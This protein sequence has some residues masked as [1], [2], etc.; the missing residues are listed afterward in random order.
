MRLH[1]RPGL[2]AS[3]AL[4]DYDAAGMGKRR[5]AAWNRGTGIA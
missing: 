5:H 1:F 2:D 3:A 4:R